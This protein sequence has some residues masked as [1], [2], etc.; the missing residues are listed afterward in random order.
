MI[1]EGYTCS[2]LGANRQTRHGDHFNVR[3]LLGMI[4]V[5]PN[6]SRLPPARHPVRM[7]RD[8]NPRNSSNYTIR[9][10]RLRANDIRRPRYTMRR[11]ATTPRTRRQRRH[12]HNK[13]R[14]ARRRRRRYPNAR[15][16]TT[17]YP[18][19]GNLLFEGCH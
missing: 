8:S 15:P 2:M 7:R 17:F 3:L 10:I 16:S 4:R 13:R 19:Q 18:K 14:R 12:Y 11:R 5:V 1:F 6:M 9:R